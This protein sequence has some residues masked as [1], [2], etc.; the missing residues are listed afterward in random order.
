M[1]GGCLQRGVPQYRHCLPTLTQSDRLVNK[2]SSTTL[3]G[4]KKRWKGRI[5][6]HV[7]QNASS[8]PGHFLNKNSLV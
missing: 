1:S 5:G 7:P 6:S 2:A 3:G 4:D 8:V